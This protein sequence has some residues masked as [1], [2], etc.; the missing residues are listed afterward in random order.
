M[1]CRGHDL[2]HPDQLGESTLQRVDA[3]LAYY[4]DHADDFARAEAE[5]RNP[6]VVT[7][8]GYATMATGYRIAP[9]AEEY[10]EGSLAYDLL[11]PNG[12]AGR[13]QQAIP[14]KYLRKCTTP[15]TTLE[16][17][18]DAM[19]AGHFDDIGPDNPLGIVTQESQWPRL[20]WFTHK[21][22]GALGLPAA[23]VQLIKAPGEDDPKVIADEASLTSMTKWMYRPFRTP[24][25]LRRAD[26][27]AEVGASL[28]V[29][30]GLK[31]PP[32]LRYLGATPNSQ[33]EG[34]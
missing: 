1:A 15:R 28:L 13:H 24:N 23:S 8:G 27:I 32:G 17:V 6:V 10:R 3:T 2:Q 14:L 31:D 25:G 20:A 4:A 29:K 30:F 26:R 22:I 12:S 5:G 9:P 19:E 33:P 21:A 7:S 11:A 34:E 18:L 16:V